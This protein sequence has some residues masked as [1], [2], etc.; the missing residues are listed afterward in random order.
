MKTATLFL[1][2][3]L[4]ATGLS[5]C[6]DHR[7]GGPASPARLRLRSLQS[8]AQTGANT[9]TYTYTYS[10]DSLNRTVSIDRIN[11]GQ[12]G[13][14]VIVYG[15]PQQQY[16]FMANDT[17]IL[18]LDYPSPSNLQTGSITPYPA[19]WQGANFSTSRYGVVGTKINTSVVIRSYEFSFDADKQPSSYVDR[20]SGIDLN[21]FSYRSTNSNVTFE[22][23]RYAAG[24]GD[25]GTVTYTYDDKPNSLFSLL[26]PTIGLV[27]RFSRNNVLIETR[28]S[29]RSNVSATT[30][31][32]YEYNAQGLPTKRTATANGAVTETLLYTYES[33]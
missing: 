4:F 21:T 8:T 15:D 9:F 17:R 1:L 20:G 7:L 33:Y 30:T 28:T 31:Y 29:D 32:A 12:T 2:V 14:A 24:R 5:S 22:Q 3:T 16:T 11:D 27:Q 13:R 6:L 25:R 10:Y 23:Y 18:Y 19:N 26:D